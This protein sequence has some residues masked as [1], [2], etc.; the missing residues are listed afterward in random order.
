MRVEIDIED[1]KEQIL[2][3][4]SNEELNNELKER[5]HVIEYNKR[6]YI[7]INIDVED[8]VDQVLEEAGYNDLIHELENR[9]VVL[10]DENDEIR[11]ISNGTWKDLAKFLGLKSHA[12]KEQIYSEIEQLI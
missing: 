11:T 1:Y 2:K 3:K 10:L 7:E 8:V 4:L 6:K 5:K 9:N 12:T